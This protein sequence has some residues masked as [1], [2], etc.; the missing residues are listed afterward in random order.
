MNPAEIKEARLALG[1]TQK[2]LARLLGYQ[3]AHAHK[4]SYHLETGALRF[5]EP[6]RRL[7]EAYL[8]GYRPA[9]WPSPPSE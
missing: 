5:G 8:S 3:G 9:D 1:L 6:Q 2:A 7:L 4:A